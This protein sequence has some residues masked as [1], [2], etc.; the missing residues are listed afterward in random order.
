[1]G[2]APESPRGPVVLI[3]EFHWAGGVPLVLLGGKW[4]ATLLKRLLG[5]ESLRF[6]Q[7]RRAL[8]GISDKVLASSLRELERDGLVLRQVVPEVPVKTLY[9]PSD[10][11][12]SLLGLLD[13]LEAWGR[14]YGRPYGLEESGVQSGWGAISPALGEG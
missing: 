14:R 10:R 6:S 13:A 3:R 8:P 1:M 2:A 4:K 5:A 7:L 12:R 11:G 9:L